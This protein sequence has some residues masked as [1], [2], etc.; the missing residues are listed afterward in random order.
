M[1]SLISLSILALALSAQAQN[2]TSPYGSFKLDIKETSEDAMLADELT[3]TKAQTA[4]SE[5]KTQLSKL[6]GDIFQKTMDI[7]ALEQMERDPNSDNK[8]RRIAAEHL[9]KLRKEVKSLKAGYTK[10]QKE[11]TNACQDQYAANQNSY[12]KPSKEDLKSYKFRGFS[13]AAGETMVEMDLKGRPFTP[14]DTE[15]GSYGAAGGYGGG[16]GYGYGMGGGYGSPMGGYGYGYGCGGMGGGLMPKKNALCLD[17]EGRV[18]ATAPIT[19]AY[20]IQSNRM[21]YDG[22][23]M[24]SIEQYAGRELVSSTEYNN[25]KSTT[26]TFM[27]GQT[28]STCETNYEAYGGTAPGSGSLGSPQTQR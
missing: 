6:K 10:A 24:K 13:C 18:T 28:V 16:M 8:D 20:V 22:K 25:R 19:D 17:K 5:T 9:A 4:I 27:N 21:K 14:C 2:V 15:A 23:A 7:R 26:K 11:H 1:K 3:W 12:Y